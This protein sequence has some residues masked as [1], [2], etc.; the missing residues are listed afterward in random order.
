MLFSNINAIANGDDVVLAS[1]GF[2]LRS[3]NRTP[4]GP[5]PAPAS[6]T[7]AQGPTTGTLRASVPGVYGSYL[8]TARL[9]LASAPNTYIQTVQQ[10]G[11]R[12]LFE[13]L[14]PGEVYNVEVN[15]IGAAGA[16]DWSDDGTLR[17]I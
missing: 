16:S 7:M 1:C 10:T 3:T 6:P 15:A 13:G 14:T 9:A 17:V 2:P 5:L 4:I 11:T 8:Y 12:F